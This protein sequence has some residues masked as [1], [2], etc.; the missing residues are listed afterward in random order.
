MFKDETNKTKM[1]EA[2]CTCYRITK[3]EIQQIVIKEVERMELGHYVYRDSD[4]NT[5]L[6][7]HFGMSLFKTKEDAEQELQ[8]RKI[9]K[10]KRKLL[11][12]YERNLNDKFNLKD[13][14][15]IK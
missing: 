5:Y 12:E 2:G 9:I 7:R 15:I 13:H 4:G 11:K 3:G 6:S 10:E 1:C 14:F 8:R